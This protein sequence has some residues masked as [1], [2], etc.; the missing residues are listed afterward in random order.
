MRSFQILIVFV[1]VNS[2]CK[3]LQF[4]GTL[5]PRPLPGAGF[6][7]GHSWAVA[8]QMKTPG[9]PSL[10]QLCVCIRANVQLLSRTAVS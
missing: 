3:L 10:M 7:G 6:T 2:V 8:S 4:R 1:S 5:Y 9:A